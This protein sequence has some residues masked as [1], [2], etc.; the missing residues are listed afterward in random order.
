MHSRYNTAQYECRSLMRTDNMQRC[1]PVRIF[2]PLFDWSK[3]K[4]ILIA[5]N[6]SCAKWYKHYSNHSVRSSL[7]CHCIACQAFKFGIHCPATAPACRA[8][9]HKLTSLRFGLPLSSPN[10]SPLAARFFFGVVP[11]LPISNTYCAGS[12][13]DP[14]RLC[15]NRL[16]RPAPPSLCP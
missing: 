7:F 16:G 15:P 9:H 10:P 8:S 6:A 3:G 1:L 5:T 12:V 2:V 13:V 4:I 14:V 11:P